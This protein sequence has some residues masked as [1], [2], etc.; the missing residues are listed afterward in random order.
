MHTTDTDK[1]SLLS[2]RWCEQNWRQVKTVFSSPH[3]ISKLDKQFR[4][5]TDSLDLSPILFTP[6]TRTRQDK[7][8][9]SCPYRRCEL[10]IIINSLSHW[11]HQAPIPHF[12]ELIIYVHC[13]HTGNRKVIRYRWSTVGWCQFFWPD[14]LSVNCVDKNKTLT[15]H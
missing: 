8:V 12:L 15:R 9:L 11:R 10:V 13:S 2:C 3:R 1:K 5:V 6:P 7:T 14:L 4:I